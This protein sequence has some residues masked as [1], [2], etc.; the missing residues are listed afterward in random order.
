MSRR[1]TL[2]LTVAVFLCTIIAVAQSSGNF[3]YGTSPQSQ[4]GCVLESNGSIS[5]GEQCQ[6][7]CNIDASGNSTCTPTS[8][9]CMDHAVAGIKTSAGAGNIFVVRP[10]AVIGLLTDV[11]V[12]SK[13]SGSS[14]GAVSSS[15]L[16]GVDFQVSV[17]G[18]SGPVKVIPASWITFDSRYIQI[19]TNLFQALAM[20]CMAINGGCFITFN[21]STVSAHSFDFLAGGPSSPLSS[22]QYTVTTTWKSALGG[23]G[24][25]E[26]LTCVGPLNMTVQQNKVFSFNTINGA[27]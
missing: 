9:T 11:T 5:G 8:G 13:Q 17:Q 1:T 7:S 4:T 14:T 18:P 19:S 12:S 23:S 25:S 6:M 2:C 15:A 16:A 24:I 10:S 27:P 20:Q 21:E 22:G 26:S 3:S